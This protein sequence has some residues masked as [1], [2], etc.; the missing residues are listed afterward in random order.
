MAESLSSSP[1]RVS[2]SNANLAPGPAVLWG[3]DQ[4][5]DY[6]A[7]IGADGMEWMPI[8]SRFQLQSELGRQA[9]DGVVTS[10]HA[11]FRDY[12]IVDVIRR[13]TGVTDMKFAIGM[14]RN[15]N[16][17]PLLV[18]QNWAGSGDK[19]PVV[20]YPNEQA[21]INPTGT[22]NRHTDF[23]RWQEQ[24]A[25][26]RFQPTAELLYNWGVLSSD[27]AVAMQGMKEVMAQRGFDGVAFDTHHWTTERG[28]KLMPNWRD[29]LPQLVRDGTAQEMHV[30]PARP[31][32]G[33]DGEQLRFI[34]NDF[35]AYTEV[36]DMITCVAENL[37]E[38]APFDFVLELPHAATKDDIGVPR[39]VIGAIRDHFA[40][41]A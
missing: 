19:L 11:S 36:G 6:I 20:A 9:L 39:M 10:L 41:A 26:V 2:I 15:E 31:D 13:R 30:C 14:S 3:A 35:I 23:K 27:G 38:N 4:L 24:F 25:S 5:K 32:V 29:S 8:R 40:Q 12:S 34:L 37:P 17:G 28:G 33:G 16:I 7:K 1:P 22:M 18:M 21:L